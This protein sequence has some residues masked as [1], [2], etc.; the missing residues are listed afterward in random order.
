MRNDRHLAIKLRKKNKS[1][2]EIS[3]TLNIPKSTLAY[4]FRNA[5]WS[6]KIKKNLIKEAQRKAKRQLR[7]M[8]KAR[9]KFWEKCHQSYREQAA[10]EFPILKQNPLLLAGLML[11]WGEGD[12]KIENGKVRLSNIDPVMIR[13]FVS[14]LYSICKI[15]R[16]KIKI[17]IILYPDLDEQIC[18]KYWNRISKIPL[19]QFEKVQFIQGR[20][21]TKRLSHGICS[22]GVSS[23]ELKEKIFVWLKLYQKELNNMRE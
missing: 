21:P 9:K 2:N 3:Q 10:K 18:K 12:S 5:Y 4:W 8:V 11:Y 16:E 14:F 17:F 20:H 1:Y 19:S 15:P 13:L 6:R 23:R 7:L 22:V